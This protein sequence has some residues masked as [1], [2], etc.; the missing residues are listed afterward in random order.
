MNT[1]FYV[2]VYQFKSNDV[3]SH[4]RHYHHQVQSILYYYR[5]C[6]WQGWVGWWLY[7][8]WQTVLI[9][10]TSSESRRPISRLEDLGG[11]YHLRGQKR[12]NYTDRTE[13]AYSCTPWARRQCSTTFLSL[14]HRLEYLLGL[15]ST[16]LLEF[17]MSSGVV[18]WGSCRT[19][20]RN[21]TTQIRQCLCI[22]VHH[23]L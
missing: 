4:V 21:M 19:S 17:T 14:W 1:W 22:P 11:C 15:R 5:Q 10:T 16:V 6:W 8:A 23:E 7:Y 2:S 18:D 9:S 3:Q 12:H 20:L 13:L